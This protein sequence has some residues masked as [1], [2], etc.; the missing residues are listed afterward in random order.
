MHIELTF[1]SVYALML[2]YLMDF[3]IQLNALRIGPSIISFK[4]SQVGISKL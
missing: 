4:G 1:G 2:C 3:S